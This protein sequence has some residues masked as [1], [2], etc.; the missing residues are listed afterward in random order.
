M[1]RLAAILCSG[2]LAACSTT[3]L[4]GLGADSNFTCK[5]PAGVSCMSVSGIHANA[6]RGSLPALR[7][8]RAEATSQA[9]G[10]NLVSEDLGGGQRPVQGAE[11]GTPPAPAQDY[12]KQDTPVSPRALEAPYSGM[13][14]RSPTKVARIWI[15]P[16]TD[17]D[18]DL[19]DQRFLYVT[20]HTGKWLLE[21]N[22]ISIE[23][24]FRPVYQLGSKGGADGDG[25]PGQ[26][27]AAARKAATDTVESAVNPAQSDAEE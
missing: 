8:M 5:A 9:G 15:A 18:N 7:T 20:V 26:R 2:A 1:K 27:K 3:S 11:G 10:T 21:A 23:R 4:S 16:A 14:L 22:Q 6:T 24:Q 13:P 25:A 19:H 12:V 17:S